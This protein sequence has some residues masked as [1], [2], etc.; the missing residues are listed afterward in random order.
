MPATPA[1]RSACANLL[2]QKKY[3]RGTAAR[4]STERIRVA[5]RSERPARLIR[6]IRF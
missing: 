1:K 3:Y 5:Q 6:H 4:C 2:P